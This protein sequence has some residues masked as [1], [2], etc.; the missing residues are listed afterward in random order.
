MFPS[1]GNNAASAAS[2]RLLVEVVKVIV[3]ASE[4]RLDDVVAKAEAE[5]STLR[6][7][8]LAPLGLEIIRDVK[9]GDRA[10][11]LVKVPHAAFIVRARNDGHK[12]VRVAP[13]QNTGEAGNVD[14]TTRV[15]RLA[16]SCDD[17]EELLL[18]DDTGLLDQDAGDGRS[19]RSKSTG[20][21][22]KRGCDLGRARDA[23]EPGPIQE[24]QVDSVGCA[25]T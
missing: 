22:S 21:R 2:H 4:Q 3:N 19:Q 20:R 18:G 17:E 6:A 16:V 12:H 14:L 1:S 10:V 13:H 25:K 5:G 7:L 8:D 9:P 23:V 24:V 11:E 15:R